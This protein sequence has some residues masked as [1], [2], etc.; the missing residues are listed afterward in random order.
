MLSHI[1]RNMY[2]DDKLVAEEYM[3]RAKSGA[4]KEE[5]MAD[6]LKCWNLERVLEAEAYG[7]SIPEELTMEEF[8]QEEEE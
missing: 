2:I 8:E 7:E 3:K 5:N 1:L 4:W 6:A